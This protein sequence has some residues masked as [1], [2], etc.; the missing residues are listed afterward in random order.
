MADAVI[1]I[2]TVREHFPQWRVSDEG[3]MAT[4]PYYGA[5]PRAE[6]YKPPTFDVGQLKR[7]L[8]TVVWAAD[9]TALFAKIAEQERLRREMAEAG[10]QPLDGR[11]YVETEKTLAVVPDA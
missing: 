10:E 4:G 8:A 7:G 3:N 1:T 2:E 9:P 5:R 6:E 11:T